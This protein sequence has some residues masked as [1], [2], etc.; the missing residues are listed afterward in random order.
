MSLLAQFDTPAS[1]RDA[2]AGSPFYLAWHN[3]LAAEI[4][5]L[6][7]GD[8]GGGFYDATATDVNVAGE[9]TLTW[10]GFPRRVL[11]SAANRDNKRAAYIAADADV[12]ARSIQDEYF[13][14][15][16]E[17]NPAGK[18]RK[19]TFITETPE[20]YQ[21]LWNTN[22]SLVVGLYQ[23][24]VNPGI[25]QANIESSPGVYDQFNQW[26][27]T[28]GIVHYIQGINTLRA[29]IGLSEGSVH[30]APLPG[31]NYDVFGLTNTSVDPRVALDVHMMVR[32]G[33]LVTLKDPIGLY[34]VEWN[35]SG[36]S[37]PDGTPVG[38]YWRIV[39]GGAGRTLRLEYEVPAAL[40]F[41]VGDIKSGGHP[42]EFGGQIAEHIT[43]S[44]TGQAGVRA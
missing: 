35:D 13:E 2:P 28:R 22:P 21:T 32:K 1:L 23:T 14:W 26:N 29:A 33:L 34:M 7:P 10:M 39:R 19:V 27:T 42:I 43:V 17:R 24:L 5:D 38:N 40:G 9:K 44:I 15:F 18:I 6:T 41:V 36:F 3:F 16:V 37:K 4:N 8:S 25:V 31:D 11:L 20:Y 12:A 30:Q